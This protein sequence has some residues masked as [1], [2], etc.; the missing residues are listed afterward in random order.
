MAGSSYE[1]LPASSRWSWLR[2]TPTEPKLESSV[3]PQLHLFRLLSLAD[4]VSASASTAGMTTYSASLSQAT[5]KAHPDVL[6]LVSL[7]SG[8]VDVLVTVDGSGRINRVVARIQDSGA[9]RSTPG[10]S[11]DLSGCHQ[12]D[13]HVTETLTIDGFGGAVRVTQPPTGATLRI[14]VGP[15]AADLP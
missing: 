6:G 7:S 13:V 5:L 3:S 15:A 11:P 2:F 14:P 1:S 8:Q 12:K 10:V 9:T 4:E